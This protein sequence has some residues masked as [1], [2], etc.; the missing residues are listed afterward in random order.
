MDST[1][2]DLRSDRIMVILPPSNSTAFA[3]G[4]SLD[5][6]HDSVDL[7]NDM[8]NIPLFHQVLLGNI[9]SNNTLISLLQSYLSLL[10]FSEYYNCATTIRAFDEK[11]LDMKSWKSFIHLLTRGFHLLPSH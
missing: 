2:D 9:E 8:I 5:D 6:T 10:T 3:L 7:I 11:G 1:L 4:A